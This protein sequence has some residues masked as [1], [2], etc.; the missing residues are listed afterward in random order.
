MAVAPVATVADEEPAAS[1]RP[2]ERR[3]VRTQADLSSALVLF[4]EGAHVV[5]YD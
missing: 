3:T 5:S 4:W 2:V 1:A